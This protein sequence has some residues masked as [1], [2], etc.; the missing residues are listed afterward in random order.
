MS[1]RLPTPITFRLP[2]GWAAADPDQAGAPQAAFVAIHPRS[3]GASP[4]FTPNIT[5]AAQPKRPESSM[6]EVA[7]ASVRAMTR[8]GG[9]TVTQRAEFGSDAA[10]GL[11]QRLLLTTTVGGVPR[12]LVQVHVFVTMRDTTNAAKQALLK[13]VLTST[14]DQAPAAVRDFERFLATVRAAPTEGAA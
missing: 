4:G 8:G 6:V 5:I 7:E 14:E 13:I 3:D 12:R 1:T 10:P 9:V 11:T 2:D